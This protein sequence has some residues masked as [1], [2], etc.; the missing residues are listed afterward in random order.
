MKLYWKD[1]SLHFLT[2]WNTVDL[3]IEGEDE[4]IMEQSFAL[5]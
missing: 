4:E 3:K 5:L 1:F 2:L